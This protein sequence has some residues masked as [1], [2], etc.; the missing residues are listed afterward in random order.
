MKNKSKLLLYIFILVSFIAVGCSKKPEATITPSKPKP[1]ETKVPV[2]EPVETP[3]KYFS[4]YTG[5]AVEKASLDN[6]A[7]LAIVENLVAARPQSGLNAADIVYETVAE[8]GIP[9]FIAVFQKNNAQKIG[10]IRSAR[11][12]FLDIAKEYNLPFAHCGGSAEAITQIQNENLMSM[13]EFAYGSTYW[14]DKVRKA[15]HNLYTSSEKLNKLIKTK[16][17]VKAPTV[18]LKF[19]KSYWDSDK[20]SNAT[21]IFLKISKAYNTRYT[22]KDGVYLKSMDEKSAVNKEDNLPLSTKNIVVQF[23]SIK[24]QADG[25]HLDIAIVGSGNGY[26]ISSGKFVKMHWSKKDAKSKTL[27]T[28]DAGNELPLNPGNTWWNIVDKNT[29]VDIK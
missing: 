4:P 25:L 29:V 13:N 10:P 27:L 22:Y 1:V 18:K 9:R 20:F 2:P 21:D 26:V 7:V 12:Y 16:N 3:P 14:R 17:Y 28:D 24:L 8:G 11:P 6:I 15:P 23:T 5:E 19:D